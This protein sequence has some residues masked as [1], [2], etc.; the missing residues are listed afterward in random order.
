MIAYW[1][2]FAQAHLRYAGMDALVAEA[3]G[4]MGVLA[5]AH[6]HLRSRA[7]LTLARAML[8]A[9]DTRGR[10]EEELLMYAYCEQAAQDLGDVAQQRWATH[11]LAETHRQFGR[12]L[13]ARAEFE[14]ALTLAKQS[15]DP[16]AEFVEVHRL[17]LIDSQQGRLVE[18]RV[19][20]SGRWRLHSSWTIR[21]PSRPRYTNWPF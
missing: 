5:W 17:T 16:A 21:P 10:R 4:L 3:A 1:I 6:G 18:A 14:R 15:G 8:R 11:Q 2:G 12:I 9:W 13:E 20:S 7:V 19:R